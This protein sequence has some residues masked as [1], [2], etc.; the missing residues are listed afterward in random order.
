[1][2][3]YKG[4]GTVADKEKAVEVLRHS[5]LLDYPEAVL[6]MKRIEPENFLWQT[7]ADSLEIDFPDFVIIDE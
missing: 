2:C 7:K 1:M 4:L 3:Y 6:E 5:A